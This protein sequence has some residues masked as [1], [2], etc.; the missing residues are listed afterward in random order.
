MSKAAFDPEFFPQKITKPNCFRAKLR[1][2]LMYKKSV[3]ETDTWHQFHEYFMHAFYV[4]K[5]FEQLFS[6]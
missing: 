1:K 5:S 2:A 3:D 4:Q 6:A